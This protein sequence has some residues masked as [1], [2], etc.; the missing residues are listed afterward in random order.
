MRL[1]TD[2]AADEFPLDMPNVQADLCQRSLELADADLAELV[3]L[4]WRHARCLLEVG[5]EPIVQCV[6]EHQHPGPHIA[7]GAETGNLIV[8]V[9]WDQHRRQIFP[10][11]YCPRE[12]GKGGNCVLADRH[13][14]RHAIGGAGRDHLPP[15]QTHD[16]TLGRYTL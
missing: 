6:H 14:G 13:A 3:R 9:T 11:R 10:A 7:Y 5:P 1:Y 12:S 2:V 15:L 4:P 8:W 16:H